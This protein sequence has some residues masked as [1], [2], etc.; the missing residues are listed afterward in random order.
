MEDTAIIDLYWSRSENAIS[1]TANKYGNFCYSIAYNVLGSREDSQECVNDTYL[2]AWERIPPERPG[3]LSAFLAKITRNL[4]ISRWRRQSAAKRGGGEVVLALE[5]LRDCA[6]QG[7]NVESIYLYKET[8]QVFKEFLK[9]LSQTERSVFLRRY[10]FLDSIANIARDFGFSQ[11][12]VKSML[13]RTRN[14]LRLC[15]EKEGCM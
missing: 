15:M 1:E 6:A 2:A 5:E 13:M 4:S 3:C 14:K 12:K 7:Q 11:S 8:I 9:M 10:F